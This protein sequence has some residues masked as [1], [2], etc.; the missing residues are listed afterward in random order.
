MSLCVKNKEK[1]KSKVFGVNKLFLVGSCTS[2]GCR[3]HMILPVALI[4]VTKNKSGAYNLVFVGLSQQE[5]LQLEPMRTS[6]SH[7]SRAGVLTV[8]QRFWFFEF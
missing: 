5:Y 6:I 4:T 3:A 8:L 1:N 2:H 7:P